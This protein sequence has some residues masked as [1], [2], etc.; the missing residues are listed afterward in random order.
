MS[1]YNRTYMRHDYAKDP[2]RPW[3]LRGILFIL[4]GVFLLQNIARHWFGSNVFEFLFALNFTTL[5]Q[6]FLHTLLTYGFLHSTDNA[7]PWHLVFNCLMLYWF[8]KELEDR[9][10]SRRFLEIFLFSTLS[11]GLIWASL[12]FSIGR[13]G[14]VVGASAACFG[15][16]Y[17]FCRLRWHATLA[18]FLIPI[19]FTGR[20]LFLVLLGFQLFFFVF[21]ELPGS[22]VSTAY[23]AHL[24]GILG[25]F[26][27]ERFFLLSGRNILPFRRARRDAPT[28]I[29]PPWE[30]HAAKARPLR[31]KVNVS[32]D[33]MAADRDATPPPPHPSADLRAE[34]DRI[35]D[36]INAHGF[37]SLTQDEKSTLDR[38]KD[39]LR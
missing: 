28:V 8:G 2:E 36:K 24:G 4:V 26:V 22:G 27:Y 29:P 17:L 7:L 35:L 18:F 19:Q 12:N 16:I 6:G 11:G 10:G 23:S 14:G 20:Q 1:I 21:G 9:Y 38:A 31:Q 15:L 32:H 37:G 3:A 34:V 13:F 30:Q 25:A 5:N 33:A 39:V